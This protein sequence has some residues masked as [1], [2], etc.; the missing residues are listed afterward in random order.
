MEQNKNEE[1]IKE[2]DLNVRILNN[3]NILLKSILEQLLKIE[4]N[5]KMKF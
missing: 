4:L 5:P 1:I 2:L 3:E